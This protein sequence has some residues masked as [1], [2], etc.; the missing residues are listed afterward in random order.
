MLLRPAFD[1]GCVVFATTNRELAVRDGVDGVHLLP[2]AN[3]DE[4]MRALAS[5]IASARLMRRVRPH[6]V[7]TTGALPG[8]FCLIFGRL[9]GA[10]TIWIDSIA[11][12]DRP[13]LSGA[14]ARPFATRWY[15]QWEHLQS[16]G[17]DY[18]GALL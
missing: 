3:R 11:A 15:T 2:D 4:P 9:L 7:V 18:E 5:M 1:E 17:R 8:L 14:L 16:P 12:S 10:R 13:S 6:V